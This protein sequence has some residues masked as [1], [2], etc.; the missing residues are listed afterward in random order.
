MAKTKYQEA[1]TDY[2]M[3]YLEHLLDMEDV[4]GRNLDKRLDR[5]LDEKFRKYISE[6][7]D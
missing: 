5:L 7:T 1:A 3:D 2:A 6:K 4:L